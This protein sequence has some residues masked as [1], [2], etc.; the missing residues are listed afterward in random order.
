VGSPP[1]DSS[2]G[3][4][5]A[6][7]RRVILALSLTVVPQMDI[8]LGHMMRTLAIGDIHGC[9]TALN[10]LLD[11][12]CP[13]P[14]DRIV[15]LGDYID[16]GPASRQVLDT[17]LQLEKRCSPVF[18]RGNHELMILDAR[19]DTLKASLWQSCGGS[20]TLASYGSHGEQG[21]AS[22]IPELHWAFFEGTL[23]FFET[24]RNVFIHACLDPELD[25]DEQPDWLLFWEF[26]ER[27]RP[28][29]SGKRIICGHT[30]QL[31]GLPANVG[32]GVCIDTGSVFGGWL[33]CFDTDS[34]KYWQANENGATRHGKL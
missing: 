30:P 22:T 2:I 7:W 10:N 32:F 19:D 9:H 26:F 12:V 13:R 14:E 18:V 6:A 21:W 17:L 5:Q 1:E 28:H 3:V 29:K 27:L 31:S 11:A 16:R 4:W 24:E 34:G 25:M 23:R 33:T 8:P 20:E 15:F